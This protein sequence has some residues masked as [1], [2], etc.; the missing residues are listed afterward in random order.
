VGGGGGGFVNI[1]AVVYTH[2]TRQPCKFLLHILVQLPVTIV[3]S[4]NAYLELIFF[5][6]V[7][8]EYFW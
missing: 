4:E 3:F 8:N 1:L 6:V 5:S 2:R 7:I